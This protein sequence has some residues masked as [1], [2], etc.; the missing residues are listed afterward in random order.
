MYIFKLILHTHT[1]TMPPNITYFIKYSNTIKIIKI[2][3][4]NE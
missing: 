4:E 3:Q 2:K 1:H